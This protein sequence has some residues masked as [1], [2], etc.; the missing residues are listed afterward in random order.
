MYGSLNECIDE[1]NVVFAQGNCLRND[2]RPPRLSNYIPVS[3][4]HLTNCEKKINSNSKLLKGHRQ[5]KNCINKHKQV[6]I[7]SKLITDMFAIKI[8]RT[9]IDERN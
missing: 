5:K 7:Y 6:E 9:T 3:K 2:L 4:G 1:W 8:Q